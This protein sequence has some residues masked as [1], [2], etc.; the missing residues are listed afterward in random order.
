MS[1]AQLMA[2]TKEENRLNEEANNK[3]QGREV[4]KVTTPHSMIADMMNG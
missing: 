2:L 4:R 3:A 1:M